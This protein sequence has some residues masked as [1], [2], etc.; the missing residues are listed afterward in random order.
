MLIGGFGA[1]FAPPFRPGFHSVCRPKAKNNITGHSQGRRIRAIIS[2]PQTLSIVGRWAALLSS[3]T[4]EIEEP[5][6]DTLFR[7]CVN[8]R[9]VQDQDTEALRL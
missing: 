3:E 8:G 7:R 6:F 2:T 1:V 4:F 9:A 5:V